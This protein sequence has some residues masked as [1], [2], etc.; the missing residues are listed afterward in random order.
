MEKWIKRNTN[1]F[2][3]ICVILGAVIGLI[4]WSVISLFALKS[5]VWLLT[6]VGYGVVIGFIGGYLYICNN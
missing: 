4:L 3:I 6:F 5:I 1:L 2:W